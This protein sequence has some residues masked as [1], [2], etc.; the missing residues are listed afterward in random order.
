MNKGQ[1]VMS[2][3]VEQ[4]YKQTKLALAMYKG[5]RMGSSVIIIHCH[6]RRITK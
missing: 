2:V 1:K 3:V 4:S 6:R 5:R